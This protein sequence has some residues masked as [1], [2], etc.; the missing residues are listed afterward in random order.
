MKNV[1]CFISYL[2]AQFGRRYLLKKYLQILKY[3]WVGPQSEGKAANKCSACVVDSFKTVGKSISGEAGWENA[4]SVQ[5]GGYLKNHTF[6]V[7]TWFH[8]CYFIVLMSL[9]LFYNVENS[10]N[11]EKPL[12]EKVF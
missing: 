8:V 12:N 1:D 10:K 6:L 11:K 5:K 3:I 4:K 7:I 9:L 2:I